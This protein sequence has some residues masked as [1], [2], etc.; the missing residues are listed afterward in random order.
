MKR[1]LME[2]NPY[3]CIGEV[4]SAR[5]ET[6]SAMFGTVLPCSVSGHAGIAPPGLY[7]VHFF[8]VNPTET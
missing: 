5:A 2:F 3:L 8:T 7:V 4:R 6:P 1:L